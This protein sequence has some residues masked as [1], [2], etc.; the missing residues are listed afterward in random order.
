MILRSAKEFLFTED[1][2]FHDPYLLNDMKTSVER[3]QNAV[4]HQEP[5]LIYGD[6]DADGVTS[7]SIL[8]SVL[9]DMGANVVIIY[10]IDSLK[11]TDRTKMHFVRQRLVASS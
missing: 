10:R 4:E 6:Y 7:T 8:M 11:D 5:I 1:Q 2:D 9:N 3:I